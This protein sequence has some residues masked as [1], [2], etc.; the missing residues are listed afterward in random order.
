LNDR[1]KNAG[2]ARYDALYI[3]IRVHAAL[4]LFFH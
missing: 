3:Y 4:F 1:F 2:N